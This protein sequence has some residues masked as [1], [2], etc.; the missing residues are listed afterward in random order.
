MARAEGIEGFGQVSPAASAEAMFELGLLYCLGRGVE[1]DLVT[2]H[3]W[4][5]IAAMRGCTAARE[6]R[7]EICRDMTAQQISEAQRGA[8]EWIGQIAA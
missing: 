1:M 2:A 4:F 3:K 7:T 5:N 8:R 6:Y